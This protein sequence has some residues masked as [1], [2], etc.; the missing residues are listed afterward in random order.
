MHALRLVTLAARLVD[1]A[2]SPGRFPDWAAFD[3]ESYWSA[4]RV[5]LE[6]WNRALQSFD[7]LAAGEPTR[8]LAQHGIRPVLHEAILAEVHCRVWTALLQ[9]AIGRGTG[10]SANSVT[11]SIWLG[12]QE[13]RCKI[14]AW[15][16]QAIQTSHPQAE[17]IDRLRRRTDHWSDVLLAR[18]PGKRVTEFAVDAKRLKN[19]RRGP[20][21]YDAEDRPLAPL[22]ENS[23]ANLFPELDDQAAPNAALNSQVFAATAAIL[24]RATTPADAALS[25]LWFRVED[26][27]RRMQEWINHCRD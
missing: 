2:A 17:E 20:Q 26:T 24:H 16:A 4:S 13:T 6:R 15:L 14:L 25:E 10:R 3:L 5:R 18:I 23:F 1:Q 7:L 21:G 12:Q 19:L 11:R 8:E 9:Q 22:V 27:S